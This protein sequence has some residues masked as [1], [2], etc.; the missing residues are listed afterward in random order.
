MKIA[1]L[2]LTIMLSVALIKT[3]GQS[4]NPDRFLVKSGYIEYELTGSTQGY[5]KIWWDDHGD[6][7]Y[8][9]IK[10]N[11]EVKFMGM[12]QK[13]ETHSITITVGDK[14]W[15][16]NL[17]ENSGIKGTIPS[18]DASEHY[19]ENLTEAEKKQFEDNILN[20]FGGERLEPEMFL[21]H[22]CD[23]IEVMGAKSWIYKGVILK[24][25][26]NMMGIEINEIAVKFDENKSI[27][28]S[29]FYP[30]NNVNYEEGS[31]E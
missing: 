6:K 16:L 25:T 2:L 13:E 24:S 4:E 1:T 17:L 12:V 9:E 29:R 3:K 28:A 19:S 20:A 14:F 21:G 10:S 23:V 26:A 7:E 8:E 11:S 30:P 5:K 27:P 18:Y 15:S 31:W 22:K